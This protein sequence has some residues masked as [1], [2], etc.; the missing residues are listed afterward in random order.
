MVNNIEISVE[1]QLT[2]SELLSKAIRIASVAFEGVND[3]GGRPYILHCLWVMNKV[4]HLGDKYMIVAVL[5]DLLEDK[6]DW[7]AT[8]LITEGFTFEMVGAIT[9][10]TH[11]KKDDYMT[12]IKNIVANSPIATQVKLRDLEHNSR[13]TRIKGFREEDIQRIKKYQLAYTYLKENVGYH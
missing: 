3:K 6:R 4:R 10:L 12:Y 1:K 11:N 2:E 8:R 9:A 7:D 13:I 5:H